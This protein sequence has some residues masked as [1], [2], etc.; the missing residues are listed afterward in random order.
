MQKANVTV[1]I[2]AAVVVGGLF[3]AEWYFFDYRPRTMEAQMD[4]N[5]PQPEVS[6]LSGDTSRII[7]CEDPEVGTFYTDA[8]N[9]EEAEA[10]KDN[11]APVPDR[12]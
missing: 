5:A 8:K 3:A 9:C 12:D 11:Y 2:V 4:G 1:L 10:P 7:E 6:E